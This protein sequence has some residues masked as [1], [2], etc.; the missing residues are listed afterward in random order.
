[1]V[2]P[3]AYLH[4]ELVEQVKKY[5]ITKDL[6]KIVLSAKPGITGLWQVSAE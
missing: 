2:E 1:M 3:R 5:P 6:M 4:R